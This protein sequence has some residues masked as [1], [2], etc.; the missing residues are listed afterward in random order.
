V[1]AD[2]AIY[3]ENWPRLACCLKT[4]GES[5]RNL[6]P[7]IFEIV[8][9]QL[10]LAPD[11]KTLRD[12]FDILLQ[13][14]LITSRLTTLIGT[15]KITLVRLSDQGKSLCRQFGWN[16]V[17]SDWEILNRLRGIDAYLPAAALILEFT[18]QARLRGWEVIE[19]VP[20]VD[21]PHPP[22]LVLGCEEDRLDVFVLGRRMPSEKDW[23]EIRNVSHRFAIIATRK[24]ISAL[25]AESAHR[26]GVD[27]LVANAE[28]LIKE[29]K[30]G[31]VKSLFRL[32]K[33]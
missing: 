1:T 30:T 22:D 13:E 24:R 28:D 2:L 11:S 21:V 16:V 5:G 8:A 6:R 32:A 26:A 18:Y 27:C 14:H 9:S 17:E 19:L 12:P 7:Q 20:D 25:Q 33:L 31:E 23:Q 4:L 15:A 10:N 29:I 3:G